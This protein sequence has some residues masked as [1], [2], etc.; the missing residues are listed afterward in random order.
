MHPHISVHVSVG[1]FI[2]L[3]FEQMCVHRITICALSRLQCSCGGIAMLLLLYLHNECIVPAA[4]TLFML[5]FVLYVFC[6]ELGST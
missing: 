5:A 2:Y 6:L 3:F 4:V 1:E